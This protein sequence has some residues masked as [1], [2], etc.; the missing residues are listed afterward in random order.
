MINYTAQFLTICGLHLLA[1]ASPGPDFAIV[2]KQSIQRGRAAALWTAWGVGSGICVHTAYT[3]LGFGLLVKTSWL[4]FTIMKAVAAGYLAYLGL[5]ALLPPRGGKKGNANSA[6]VQPSTAD[7]ELKCDGI[8]SAQVA[9]LRAYALGF[10][11]NALNPK[12]TL[13]FVAVFSVVVNPATP[14]LI[15]AGYGIWMAVMTAIWFSLVAIF[16][17]RAEVRAAFLRMGPWFDRAMG[18]VL[19][20]L[21]VA[22]ALSS[23]NALPAR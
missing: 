2:V 23:F 19:L 1:V 15:L 9:P 10:W 13:F 12:A 11:T 3:L 18:V 17:T 5:R 6:G 7:E 21:C 20:G 22:L 14:R 8:A 4:A 16:F